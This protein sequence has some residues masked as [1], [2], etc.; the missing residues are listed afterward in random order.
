MYKILQFTFTVTC[1]C[2]LQP[3]NAANIRITHLEWQDYR[4]TNGGVWA[5]ITLQWDNAWN[6]SGKNHDA[7][8]LFFK[9]QLPGGAGQ[10]HLKVLAEG[11]ETALNLQSGA[12]NPAFKVSADRT[13]LFVYPASVYRG[14]VVWSIRI[15]LDPEFT[16]DRQLQRQLGDSKMQAYALEMVQIPDGPY[17]LG[18]PDTTALQF[19][20]F[21]RTD[22]AGQPEGLVNIQSESQVVQVGKEKGRLC[23]RNPYPEY[24]GDLQGPVPAEFP[25]GVKGFYVMKYELSQ[26][27]YADFLNMLSDEQ[28]YNRANF[29]GRDYYNLRGTIRLENGRYTADRP[30][31]PCNFISWED[32]C[33]YADWAG[34]RPMTELEFEKAARGP[35]EP[36]PH[37]FPWGTGSKNK[38]SRFIDENG[39]LVWVD[40]LD[41]SQL[42]DQNRDIFGASYYWVF[43]LSGGGVWERCI[44]I[45][46]PAGRAFKGAHG[47]GNLS[48]YGFADTADW[49][50]G[51]PD[52]E[53]WGFRGGGF[54]SPARQYGEFNPH[55]PIAYRRF[56]AWAGGNRSMA[57]GSRFVRGD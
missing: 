13:G 34:L 38:L 40:G 15:A 39:D 49:P 42:T 8:W 11:H 28:S 22:G 52:G 26:G 48:W 9:L 1:I 35:G 44:T 12:P 46:S 2:L 19:G 53:G 21:F 27:Q 5:R 10:R 25:K 43:D 7:A 4:G 31:R 6:I 45:G 23:Y 17:T 47:D 16:Q 54:Y 55:S 57:Y 50:K 37:E 51:N 20:A 29:G 33:A 24:E 32:A 41:E 30:D 14:K 18:D 3:A 56:G 36:R